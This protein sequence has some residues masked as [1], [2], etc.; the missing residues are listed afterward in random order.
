MNN[1]IEIVKNE[2]IKLLK[3]DNSGHGIDHINRVTNISIKIA[4]KEQA[5]KELVTVIARLH[6]VDDYKLFSIENE[7][8]LSN[9]TKILEKTS[10]T[11]EQ[12]KIII[13]SIKTIGYSKRLEGIIPQ[14]IEAK[15]VSDADMIES[16]GAIGILRTFQYNIKNNNPF[17]D[18]DKFPRLDMSASEY[19][20]AK[21][22]TSV[23]HLF[24][25]ILKLKAF[26]LTEYGKKE[27]TKRT[28]FIIN[29]L[30]EYFYEEDVP[31]WID[32]LNNY[33]EKA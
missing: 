31:E 20:N 12:K 4:E 25:K 27:A 13:N 26:M 32:Y 33:I 22:G 5:N 28:D 2:V 23:N 3:D 14:N 21:D 6:D 30:K 9:T 15:I 18:R 19:K 29:F 17:F 7:E 1:N 16:M 11:I 24:E 10:Y 8:N